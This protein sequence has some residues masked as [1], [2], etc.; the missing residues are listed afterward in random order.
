MKKFMLFLGIL[1][2]I[3]FSTR[4]NQIYYIPFDIPGKQMAAT[5]PPFGIFIESDF[6]NDKE[7][8]GH[9]MVH[10]DQYHKM[11]FFGY[12]S[13]Y[14]REF[15]KYGRKYGPMEVEARKLNKFK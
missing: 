13:T 4:E 12:Y 7:L 1:T 15:I 11:G 2:F 9:E 10:L 14:M 3:L 8:L 5:I 6:K